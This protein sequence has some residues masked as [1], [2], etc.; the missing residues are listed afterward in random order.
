[1]GLLYQTLFLLRTKYHFNGY[2]HVKGIPGASPQLVEAVGFL[3]DRMSLN[4]ELATAD[5]LKQLA[6]GKS[7]EKI[8]LP[9]RQI[10]KGI[11]GQR[12]LLTDG[13]EEAKLP[14]MQPIELALRDL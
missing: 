2:I 7:R 1:M 5:G 8:L 6:P 3:A 10:Q 11:H 13:K 9:M 4:L 12:L 14:I